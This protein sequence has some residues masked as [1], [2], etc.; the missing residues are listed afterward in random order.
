MRLCLASDLHSELYTDPWNACF[1]PLPIDDVDVLVLAGDILN[2]VSLDHFLN[3]FRRL[4]DRVKVVYVPGNHEYWDTGCTP[5]ESWE[6]VLYPAMER[7]ENLTVLYTGKSLVCGGKT[8]PMERFHGDTMW[9]PDTPD[10]LLVMPSWKESRIIKGYVPYVFEQNARWRQWAPFDIREGDI[11]VTHHSP[12]FLSTP[13]R[14]KHQVQNCYYTDASMENV[15]MDK[16]PKLW[17]HGH[18]HQFFDYTIGDTR[19]VCNPKG[20]LLHETSYKPGL[21]I[22]I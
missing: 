19:I 5:Q 22:E 12:S 4:C 21:I 17:L 3:T 16:K 14:Y 20:S 13:T 18:T 6:K 7:L 8:G 10:A 15:I 1:A 9:F 11:V 2:L